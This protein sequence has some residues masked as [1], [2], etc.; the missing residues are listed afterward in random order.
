M[1]PASLFSPQKTVAPETGAVFFDVIHVAAY[2]RQS[3]ADR[4]AVTGAWVLFRLGP[5]RL[6]IHPNLPKAASEVRDPP[7]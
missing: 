1:L 5:A 3:W 7:T 2:R 6:P 4:T